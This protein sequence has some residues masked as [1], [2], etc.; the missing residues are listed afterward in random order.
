MIFSHF[1]RRRG[2]RFDDGFRHSARELALDPL[3]ATYDAILATDPTVPVLLQLTEYR[4]Q[5]VLWQDPACT[6]PVEEI[7]D[8]IGGVRHP[9]TGEI[10]VVQDTDADRPVWGGREVG[11]E[12][13]GE[14]HHLFRTDTDEIPSGQSY[15]NIFATNRLKS[16]PSRILN[17]NN[18]DFTS[19]K[20]RIFMQRRGLGERF[21]W[22][23]DSGD[24]LDIRPPNPG[25]GVFQYQAAMYNAETPGGEYWL[26]G[27]LHTEEPLDAPLDDITQTV[28]VAF[29][30]PFAS[31]GGF[32]RFWVSYI[33]DPVPHSDL[34]KI[35]SIGNEQ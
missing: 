4:G 34:A 18:G 21:F 26:N 9:E 2:V 15:G 24:R 28:P 7:G 33:G 14:I 1:K 16:G 6:V 3:V 10:L 13:D 17:T 19:D 23:D 29:G 25:G 5:Q 11:A 20:G 27:E 32:I 8:P 35:T 30:G 31:F 22:R 12:F